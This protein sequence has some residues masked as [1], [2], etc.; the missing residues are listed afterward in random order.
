MKVICEVNSIVKSLISPNY[1]AIRY[2][3]SCF[4]VIET[5]NDYYLVF[6][7]FTRS[8]ISLNIEE[9]SLL[10]EYLD[11]PDNEIV[12]KL[13]ELGFLIDAQIDE[14]KRYLQL[15]NF[16]R[17]V[18]LS[19]NGIKTFKIY[20][21]TNCNAR[22]FYCFE[23]GTPK[24]NMS[25]EICD[26][27]INYIFK[28]KTD[29]KIRLYWFGGEP[30]CNQLVINRICSHLKN[31]DVKF[32]ST[33]VT[34]GYLFD[35]KLIDKAINDWNLTLVQITLDG[36]GEEHNKR[37]AYINPTEDPFE[38]TIENI[39]LLSKRNL[40]LIV[41]LNFDKNNLNDIKRLIPYLKDNILDFKNV[42]VAPVL[43][44]DNCFSHKTN[45][46]FTDNLEMNN[47]FIELK[48][49]LYDNNMLYY[50]PVNKHIPTNSCM[51]DNPNCVIISTDGRLYTCQ[52]CDE[53]M[54]Y[55]DIFNGVTD[56]KL[57]DIWRNPKKVREKCYNCVCLPECTAFDKCPVDSDFCRTNKL[58]NI[59][60]KMIAT[61]KI[62]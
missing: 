31:N 38:K 52:N 11:K 21:T 36:Y 60:K 32:E 29:D 57:L 4:N 18:R 40:K 37:K 58:Y 47:A 61:D 28:Y 5:I 20:T 46:D 1:S 24:N 35:K 53:S 49:I 59:R 7:T 22:C 42:T 48:N 19:S 43:L 10:K 34:N 50:G 41:R 33:I 25:S 45:I 15:Q 30:L 8:L 62:M 16:N 23:E 12:D 3:P 2:L 39:K 6:N 14:T 27:V 13:V 9:Y 56:S 17:A 54:C 51:A 26:A 44:I 55:G